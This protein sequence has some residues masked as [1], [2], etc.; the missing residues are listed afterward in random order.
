MTREQENLAEIFKTLRQIS[1][2]KTGFP[3]CPCI[4][5]RAEPTYYQIRSLALEALSQG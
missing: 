3:L 1:K 5:D 2:S 4:K